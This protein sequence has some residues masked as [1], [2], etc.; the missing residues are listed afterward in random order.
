[1]G[2]ADE[3]QKLKQLHDTGALTDEEFEQGKATL[4]TGHS[5]GS[6][7]PV[8][9]IDPSSSLGNAANKWVNFQVVMAVIGL[10]VAAIFFFVFWLPQWS[11]V[12]SGG[13]PPGH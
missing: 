6:R 10:I 7:E 11:R 4:L 9:P 1:M 3:L 2:L 12:S 5:P 8:R 13:L